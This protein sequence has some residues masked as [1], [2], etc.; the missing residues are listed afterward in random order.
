M[1]WYPC[2]FLSA[3]TAR[4]IMPN[5][6]A[7]LSRNRFCGDNYSCEY[8]HKIPRRKE[9]LTGFDLMLDSVQAWATASASENLWWC[10]F[11][12][13]MLQE[14]HIVPRK[15][16]HK[17]PPVQTVQ[18]AV[19]SYFKHGVNVFSLGSCGPCGFSC[20]SLCVSLCDSPS[21]CGDD[22]QV[23]MKKHFVSNHSGHIYSDNYEISNQL[24]L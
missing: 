18:C 3:L 6:A 15:R 10:G 5:T 19:L 17:L 23:A 20:A 13:V 7:W 12:G 22:S 4:K 2:C 24:K 21:I 16:Q 9:D 1:N 14:C 8:I 11:R